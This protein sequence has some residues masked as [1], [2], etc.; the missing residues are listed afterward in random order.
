MTCNYVITLMACGVCTCVFW[1]FIIFQHP[2]FVTCCDSI[3]ISKFESFRISNV[4]NINKYNSHKQ[5]LFEALSNFQSVTGPHSRQTEKCCS[6]TWKWGQRFFP[7]DYLHTLCCPLLDMLLAREQREVSGLFT[8]RNAMSS[9]FCLL[10][11]SWCI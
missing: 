11:H 1:G 4:L 2:S 5:K 8:R 10:H 6:R 9:L 3:I 7:G